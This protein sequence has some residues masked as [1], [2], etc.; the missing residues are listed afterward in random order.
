[1]LPYAQMCYAVL[2]LCV[3]LSFLLLAPDLTHAQTATASP[4]ASPSASPTASPTAS[5]SASPSASSVVLSYLELLN[6]AAQGDVGVLDTFKAQY[7]A[8]TVDA[9]TMSV[10][11][12]RATYYGNE[13][14]VIDIMTFLVSN[15]A[16]VDTMEFTDVMGSAARTGMEAAV[17]ALLNLGISPTKDNC[18]PLQQAV[19]ARDT[20][21]T[22]L[23]LDD[24]QVITGN[25]INE[26]IIVAAH[27]YEQVYMDALFRPETQAFIDATYRN[28]RA[29]IVSL[30]RNASNAARLTLEPTMTSIPTTT[31][32]TLLRVSKIRLAASFALVQD[33]LDIACATPGVCV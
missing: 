10:I 25:C 30:V 22:N 9:A 31:Y 17:T 24:G 18:L 8:G 12:S 28:H 20:S 13:A 2:A 29:W 23:L 4:A 19:V 27:D 1:M 5:P 3:A 15:G 16:P 33:A 14:G 6:L 26:A 11:A 7:L 21:M 32:A